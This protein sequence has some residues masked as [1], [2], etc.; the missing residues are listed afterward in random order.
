MRQT[1]ILLP[2]SVLPY[3]VG[4]CRLLRVPAGSWPFP[5]LSLWIFPWMLGSILRLPPRCLFPLLSLEL[6]PSP[7]S[8]RVGG[9][10]THRQAN[11]RR[12]SLSE[13]QSFTNVQASRFAR[14]PVGS[15]YGLSSK[16]DGDFYFRAERKAVTC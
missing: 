13:L 2:I 3:T 8:E 14:H 4:P 12:K 15:H 5:T 1:K 11:S 16:A 7:S 9:W 10:A 6:R